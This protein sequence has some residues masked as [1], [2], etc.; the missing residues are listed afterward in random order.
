M[1]F[2]YR[3]SRF[4]LEHVQQ[5]APNVRT[6]GSTSRGSSA[7]VLRR[8]PDPDLDDPLTAYHGANK[9]RLQTIKRRYD[10]DRFFDFPQ[11]L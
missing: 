6:P 11:A 8:G 10:P 5:T 9:E 1:A 7:P 2:A 3:N 4:L